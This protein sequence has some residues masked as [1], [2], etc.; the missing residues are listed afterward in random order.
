MAAFLGKRLNGITAQ[1][2]QVLHSGHL[3]AFF[4]ALCA[5]CSA[6]LA[7][8]HI[9]FATFVG[10]RLANNGAQ[11]AN[12]FAVLAA[13]CHRCCGQR[14]DLRAIHVQ[15][16]ARRHHLYIGLVQARCGTVVTGDGAGVTGLDAS[17]EFLRVH[18]KCS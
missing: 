7:M 17:V 10:A 6:L 18:V 11:S 8:V 2:R 4:S 3:A 12:G 5:R 16:D 14:A 15:R 1:A 9:V 13:A